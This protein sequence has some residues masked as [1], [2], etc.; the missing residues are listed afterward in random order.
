MRS[1]SLVGQELNELEGFPCLAV[2]LYI[3]ERVFTPGQHSRTVKLTLCHSCRIGTS[4]EVLTSQLQSTAQVLRSCCHGT[5][6]PMLGP[7]TWN[8]NSTRAGP[9]L[10]EQRVAAWRPGTELMNTRETCVYA[11]MFKIWP[12]RNILQNTNNGV[13][14]KCTA[15]REQLSASKWKK[16]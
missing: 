10:R 2:K 14:S 1:L 12:L 6:R 16:T 9:R 13:V 3:E 11:N 7:R 5:I 4:S 8:P 15:K